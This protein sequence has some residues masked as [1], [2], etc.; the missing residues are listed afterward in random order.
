MKKFWCLVYIISWSKKVLIH[1]RIEITWVDDVSI[2][3]YH[4]KKNHPQ[5]TYFTLTH[6]GNQACAL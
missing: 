5:I 1:S 4:E 6:N 3:K 2:V